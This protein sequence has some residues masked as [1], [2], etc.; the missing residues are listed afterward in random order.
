MQLRKMT[1][2]INSFN[3]DIEGVLWIFFVDLHNFYLDSCCRSNA[4]PPT[5]RIRT[6]T[7]EKDDME[8][9]EKENECECDIS[10][11]KSV[12]G[13]DGIT[14][15]SSCIARCHKMVLLIIELSY[16][17]QKNCI[18]DQSWYIL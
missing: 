11:D 1:V 10:F 16:I 8:E 18:C 3:F 14:Y 5:W 17:W 12:C 7:K 2:V 15:P 9:V 6:K 13:V 4:R